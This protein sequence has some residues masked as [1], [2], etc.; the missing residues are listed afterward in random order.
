MRYEFPVYR[1]SIML[2]AEVIAGPYRP[3]TSPH[4]GNSRMRSA[5]ILSR[6]E[7]DIDHIV[8]VRRCNPSF[9]QRGAC[10]PSERADSDDSG[11][12]LVLVGDPAAK[13]RATRHVREGGWRTKLSVFLLHRLALNQDYGWRDPHKQP[14]HQMLW[15]SVV[16]NHRKSFRRQSKPELSSDYLAQPPS[17]S[18]KL[19][20]S[21]HCRRARRG[22]LSQRG[23]ARTTELDHPR[24]VALM[25]KRTRSASLHQ[26]DECF[27]CKQIQYRI[28][29]QAGP[30]MTIGATSRVLL[31]CQQPPPRKARYWALL[32]LDSV[33]PW[34][35]DGDGPNNRSQM[36]RPQ[37]SL[38][39][40]SL[41]PVKSGASLVW[42]AT[43]KIL[44]SVISVAHCCLNRPT[45]K[46]QSCPYR[47]HLVQVRK[48]PGFCTQR[49]EMAPIRGF[50]GPECF[51]TRSA[52]VLAR[53]GLENQ[54]RRRGRRA[55]C[56]FERQHR[57]AFEASLVSFKKTG[58]RQLI[59]KTPDSPEV[60]SS[61]A[62][63]HVSIPEMI[64]ARA[65]P[66]L[67]QSPQPRCVGM[68]NT[69]KSVPHLQEGVAR[70]HNKRTHCHRH[71][72]TIKIL[73]I[74]KKVICVGPIH[75]LGGAFTSALF[76][77]DWDYQEKH[78]PGRIFLWCLPRD[79][80]QDGS[81]LEILQVDFGASIKTAAASAARELAELAWNYANQLELR[82]QISP[83]ACAASQKFLLAYL[84]QK[85]LCLGPV[86][87]DMGH[88][89]IYPSILCEYGNLSFHIFQGSNISPPNK[90]SHQSLPLLQC[91]RSRITDRRQ[92]AACRLALAKSSGA[93]RITSTFSRVGRF[94]RE[95]S[96]F[97]SGTHFDPAQSSGVKL[98]ADFI[99][100]PSTLVGVQTV[101]SQRI[102][103]SGVCTLEVL[104]TEE[105]PSSLSPSTY[106]W[107]A[108]S[109]G[110]SGLFAS[111][112]TPGISSDADRQ[113]TECA[114][115]S[116]HVVTILPKG[117]D[118]FGAS[119]G[120]SCD[121]LSTMARSGEPLVFSRLVLPVTQ[122]TKQSAIGSSPS[123]DS[124]SNRCAGL[125]TAEAPIT[126]PL[127]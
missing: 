112:P 94:Q 9:C 104:E 15:T 47:I 116:M 95:T 59:K 27:P 44:G 61:D 125:L 34:S 19:T 79:I 98:C 1:T 67:L 103:V 127:S 46:V 76:A 101:D 50:C 37:C 87:E 52:V 66:K 18:L 83:Q 32:A 92:F 8:A 72:A 68:R 81:F 64:L 53:H 39:S 88:N 74:C 113:A 13:T 35:T 99:I 26:P 20:V 62:G 102:L 36:G 48:G 89:S 100:S 11:F 41:S 54:N 42:L 60:C 105:I 126:T 97:F 111:D 115:T 38:C 85:R 17:L 117:S 109:N 91:E 114:F 43:T 71:Q 6:I 31:T 82:P 40:T 23:Q 110:F 73:H 3:L 57:K 120:T 24:L 22:F 30:E 5:V 55:S 25:Q 21:R 4:T 16:R 63:N 56:G 121:R 28:P 51:V 118:S 14:F 106:S 10:T 70:V 78:Q 65:C 108:S 75:K 86:G 107:I 123:P 45:G 90:L 119:F 124:D 58:L 93:I 80:I 77:T 69:C 12:Q 122:S 2:P 29:Y 7:H 96:V 33:P 84:I 49:T